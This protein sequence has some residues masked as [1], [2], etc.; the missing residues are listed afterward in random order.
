MQHI[1]CVYLILSTFGLLSLSPYSPLFS[2]ISLMPLLFFLYYYSLFYSH[3]FSIV[4]SLSVPLPRSLTVD[5]PRSLFCFLKNTQLNKADLSHDIRNR[6]LLL[7]LS[8][9][10]GLLVVGTRGAH[11][12]RQ[13]I[14]RLNGLSHF[15]WTSFVERDSRESIPFEH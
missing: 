4:L 6:G 1:P 9:R 7:F 10:A 3:L 11:L 12:C 14:T 8:V 15:L 5:T 13:A 2:F